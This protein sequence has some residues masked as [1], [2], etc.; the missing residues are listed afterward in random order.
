MAI[1]ASLGYGILIRWG[2]VLLLLALC[3][4]AL[5][6]CGYTRGAEGLADEKAAHKATKQ[7][8][9]DVLADLAEKTARAARLAD[10]ASESL[11]RDQAVADARLQE[12][13]DEANRN[14]GL[15]ADAL[16]TG[17]QQ[18]RDVWALCGPATAAGDGATAAAEAAAAGRADS[19]GR[20]SAA[21]GRDA[22][23]IDWLW[24]SWQAEHN[25]GIA[26]GCFV[27]ARP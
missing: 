18:L 23:V 2:A 24:E 7:H 3:C 4:G 10:E 13:T 15:L 6:K 20:V 11:K 27:E 22:A 19:L 25:A 14:G 5:V 8:Y 21:V 9:A 17:R 12:K 26:A 16:R 1:P